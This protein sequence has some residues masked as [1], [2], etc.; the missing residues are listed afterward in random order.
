MNPKVAYASLNWSATGVN[1]SL[2]ISATG[3]TWSAVTAVSSRLRLPFPGRV[4]I[5]TLDRVS[6][7]SASVKLKSAA[8]KV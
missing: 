2:P 3:I 6:P 1:T 5:V 8:W 4:V 7:V